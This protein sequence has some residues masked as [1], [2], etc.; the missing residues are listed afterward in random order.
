MTVLPILVLLIISLLIGVVLPS[1]WRTWLVLGVSIASVYW[2]QPALPIR[3]LDF[4]LPTITILLTVSVWTTINQDTEQQP[5]LD[6]KAMAVLIFIATLILGIS[7]TRYVDFL[8][9]IT[10]TRPPEPLTVAVFLATGGAF[11]FLPVFLPKSRRL[12]SGVLIS[13]LIGLFI[14]LKYPPLQQLTSAWLRRWTGQSIELAVPE[15]IA[16]FGFSFIAFRLLQVLFDYRSGK[17][18]QANLNETLSFSLFY[19]SLPAG[20]IDRLQHFTSELRQVTTKFSKKQLDGFQRVIWG[21]FK[22]FVLA[23]SLALI[24]LDSANS[25]QVSSTLWMWVILYAYGLRI[26]L[27]FSGYTD[28]AIGLGNFIGVNLPENFNRPYLKTNLITFWN[29]WHITLAQWFR[30]YYFNPVTRKLRTVHLKIP[31]WIIILFSQIST[32]LLIGLWHGIT[33][34]FAIWG[35]W[36]GIGL[37]INNRWSDWF[38]VKISPKIQSPQRENL[39]KF[40]GWFITFN[41]VT[42]G[43]VWFALPNLDQSIQVLSVLFGI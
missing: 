27:D 14:L 15:D 32:M 42:L 38:R 40:T 24:T 31:T 5:L 37:F 12:I 35:L 13:L 17:L 18:I 8:C 9:C 1:R 11:A 2:L 20:P 28:I 3:G 26:Y 33:W 4:W 36:H 19:P 39:F 16:W 41:Y 30:A 22:K 10:P 29:S 7:L 43:W 6:R 23:D 21:L 25:T 34:N